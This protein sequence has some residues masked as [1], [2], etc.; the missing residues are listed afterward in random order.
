MVE[1]FNLSK[2]V[3]YGYFDIR[4]GERFGFIYLVYCNGCLGS[5]RFLTVETTLL[6]TLF[7]SAFALLI[8]VSGGILYLT[9]LEWRDRRRQDQDKKMGR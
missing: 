3:S 7:W 1:I 4:L 2:A 9:T 8:I 6:I 5:R